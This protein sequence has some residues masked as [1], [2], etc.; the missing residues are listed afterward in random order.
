MSN[1][2]PLISVLMLTYNQGEFVARALQSVIIQNSDDYN[3]EVVVIDDGS[4]DNT[5]SEIEAVAAKSPIPIRLTVNDH[6][7]VASIAK[8]FLSMVNESKGDFITFLAGDDYYEP[9]RFAPHLEL[10]SDG[11]K[12]VYSEGVNCRNG[13]RGALCHPET[14]RSVM[15]SGSTEAVYRYLS[16]TS[17]VLFIQGVL[18]K[19]SF[20]RSIQPFDVDLIADDW[21]FN[22]KVFRALI[23]D[24]GSFRFDPEVRFVRNLHE[25]NTSR[26]L[27]VHYERI[28]QTAEKYCDNASL[29]KSRFI[30]EALLKSVVAKD[31]KAFVF[32]SGK[33]LSNPSALWWVA[34]SFLVKIKNRVSK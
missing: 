26:D 22:L 19:G 11:V 9:G 15:S 30:G 4:S 14:A 3:L 2:N 6:E 25:S 20:L 17:P 29:I 31:N 16:S 8:N 23:S 10:F 28:R 18:A 13:V 27:V 33:L 32:F 12:I 34:R 24:G 1:F 21:V 7:G 5:V